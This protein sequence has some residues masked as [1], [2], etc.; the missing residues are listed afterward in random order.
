MSGNTAA[1]PSPSRR[2]EW[3]LA[4]ALFA[5]TAVV[6]WPVARWLATQTFAHEQLKQSFFIVVLAGAW[7]A[8]DKHRTMHLDL[9]LSNV[10]LGW[11]ITSYALTAAALVLKTPLLFLAGIAKNL[12]LYFARLPTSQVF[13]AYRVAPRSLPPLRFAVAAA[14]IISEPI[15]IEFLEE[16]RSDGAVHHPVVG[17]ERDVH[18][19]ADDDRVVVKN[20]CFFDDS[21]HSEDR[22]LRR[23]DNRDKV[24]DV[25]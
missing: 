1:N 9:R 4:A 6:F 11:L 20:H 2:Q 15:V 10:A 22:S 23:I 8:W 5:L 16:F 19:L 25:E 3:V 24:V 18:A 14:L 7:I 17:A 12:T 21:R 13:L